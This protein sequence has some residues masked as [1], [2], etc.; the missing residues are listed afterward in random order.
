M[1]DY[2]V[3]Q[4]IKSSLQK[5]KILIMHTIMLINRMHFGGV[6]SLL[7]MIKEEPCMGTYFATL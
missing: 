4:D 3:Q 7:K 2:K 6:F 5:I 1:F